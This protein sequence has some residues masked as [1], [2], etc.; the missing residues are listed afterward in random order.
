MT[1]FFAANKSINTIF[2]LAT[3]H[4]P[5]YLIQ[6]TE[7]FHYLNVCD[8]NVPFPIN[9]TQEM[10][11]YTISLLLR[12][13]LMVCRGALSSLNK[14]YFTSSLIS[15]Y[16]NIPP[17][18]KITIRVKIMVCSETPFSKNSYRIETSQLICNAN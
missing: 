18:H 13:Q 9:S 15:P 11:E 1:I 14:N 12:K 3:L 8:A 4:D 2:L 17:L 7:R 10:R 5:C 6:Y 16:F